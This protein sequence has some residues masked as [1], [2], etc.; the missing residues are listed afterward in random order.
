[1]KRTMCKYCKEL[2]KD[3]TELRYEELGY[4]SLGCMLAHFDT[5]LK[6]VEDKQ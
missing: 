2:L 4:C 6:D 3:K 5:R 1:M